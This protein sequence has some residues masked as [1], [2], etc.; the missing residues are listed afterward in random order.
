MLPV[1]KLAAHAFMENS[2]L[3]LEA[4]HVLI[5]TAQVNVVRVHISHSNL[6]LP[7]IYNAAFAL[8]VLIQL[9]KA[10]YIVQHVSQEQTTLT[11]FQVLNHVNLVQ[12]AQLEKLST[13][14]ALLQIIHYAR[15]AMLECTVWEIYACI[16]A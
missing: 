11:S 14:S 3:Q 15:H 4:L 8:G 1:I 2:R 12:D 10:R 13:L 7:M 5:G 16:V 6:R 9:W